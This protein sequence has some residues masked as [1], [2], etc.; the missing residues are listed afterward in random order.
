LKER[1]RQAVE[2]AWPMEQGDTMFN[3]VQ[4]YTRA[5]QFEGLS[6]GSSY[7]MQ[8]LAGSILAMMNYISREHQAPFFV[9]PSLF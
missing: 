7:R 3:V 6:A 9:K 5:A 4:S 2:W 8:R 1:E